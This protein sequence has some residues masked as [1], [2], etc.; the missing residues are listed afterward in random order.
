MQ[1]S[2]LEISHYAFDI[3]FNKH[4]LT[5]GNKNIIFYIFFH[6]I[7]RARVSIAGIKAMTESN[8][9]RKAFI[10]ATVPHLS[11]SVRAGIQKEGNPGGRNL[12]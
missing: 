11:P 8:L 7:V 1:Q 10:P 9:S 3:L 12:S 2:F 5:L 6:C 4:F